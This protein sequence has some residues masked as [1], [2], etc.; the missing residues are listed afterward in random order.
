MLH[1]TTATSAGVTAT[2]ATRAARARMAVIKP[3]LGAPREAGAHPRR[4]GRPGQETNAGA[5]LSNPS[6]AKRR[7]PMRRMVISCL[8]MAACGRGAPTLSIPKN[9][10]QV[11]AVAEPR[12]ASCAR[13]TTGPLPERLSSGRQGSAVALAQLGEHLL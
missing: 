13:R 11:A 12:L 4:G 10:A 6:F 2:R 8:V 1:A 3:R 9:P 7:Q 5:A